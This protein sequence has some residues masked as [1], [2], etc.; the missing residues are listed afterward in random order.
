VAS[1][2]FALAYVW[3]SRAGR[4]YFSAYRGLLNALLTFLYMAV[5]VS[6]L[7]HSLSDESTPFVRFALLGFLYLPF[8][9][10]IPIIGAVAGSFLA[11]RVAPKPG[12]LPPPSG[13]GPQRTLTQV[14]LSI[15]PL[16]IIVGIVQCFPPPE[17]GISKAALQTY[18]EV[19]SRFDAGDAEGV[20]SLFS[21]ESKQLLDHDQF[22]AR[23]TAAWRI[24]NALPADATVAR[25]RATPGTRQRVNWRIFPVSQK[26][27]VLSIKTAPGGEIQEGVVFDLSSGRPE[28]Y[29]IHLSFDNG[30]PADNFIAPV[31][32][33]SRI[34]T[35]CG[36][37]I[38][39]PLPRPWL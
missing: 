13:E 20:Y 3:A 34:H 2:A 39:E 36:Y 10:L 8:L 24:A 29:G 11:R 22:V 28:L 9:W 25:N 4:V 27:E 38:N 12:L 35:K 7:G 19:W 21:G 17:A 33:C 31:R 32:D 15:A 16:L 23:L 14:V 6:L 30:R 5:F 18:E 37:S 26:Y 1:C